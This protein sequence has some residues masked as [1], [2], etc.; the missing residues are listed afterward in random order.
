MRAF[1]FCSWGFGVLVGLGG[2]FGFWVFF[3]GFFWLGG[4]GV[5]V[6]GLLEELRAE[7]GRVDVSCVV[8]LGRWFE[9]HG[10]LSVSDHALVMQCSVWLVNK[11]RALVGIKGR[12][13]KTRKRPLAV[14][15]CVGVLPEG[16]CSKEWLEKNIAVYGHRPI[17][18]AAGWT[19]KWYYEKLR[20]L[21]VVAR[22]RRN[23]C[24]SRDW[25]FRHYVEL[26]LSLRRCGEL[27]GVSKQTV[28][29]WLVAEGIS[30]RSRSHRSGQLVPFEFERL[31]VALRRSGVVESVEVFP[32]HLC[33][34]WQIG[35][36]SRYVFSR[37]PADQWRFGG[38]VEAGRFRGGVLGIGKEALAPLTV[39]E[40]DVS[41]VKL[42]RA[43]RFGGW[44]WPYF[45]WG[46]LEREWGF[47]VGS[48][49]RRFVDGGGFTLLRSRRRGFKLN[50]HFFDFSA[51]QRWVF[52]R[53]GIC[54][55][56][57]RSLVKSKCEVSVESIVRRLCAGHKHFYVRCPSPGL[58]AALFRSLCPRGGCVLDL[59]PGRGSRL[60]GA[61]LAKMDYL[62][63]GDAG[64]VNAESLGVGELTGLRIREWE[65]GPVDLV[66]CDA[67]I[68]DHVVEWEGRARVRVMFVSEESKEFLR[69][70]YKP[71]RIARVQASLGT[72]YYFFIW[73]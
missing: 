6:D 45:E 41:L 71:D 20:K 53:E 28:A 5:I 70:K 2:R 27:A 8:S 42:V 14:R 38:C 48:D 9:C 65:S 64:V 21:G 16:W 24:R 49:L 40:R 11:R 18:R 44:S 51:V 62:H 69:V 47:L 73:L 7:W 52:M 19:R 36:T 46:E 15:G 59:V 43:L 17:I 63:L 30:V 55:R 22:K 35:V 39:F 3:L 56:L 67:D 25:L 23:P 10:D 72:A 4:L 57:L 12:A 33:V 31:V 26:G 66:I 13:P 32:K 54:F 37:V 1:L 61:A 58:Y 50:L 60:F 34:R 68:Q 29:S